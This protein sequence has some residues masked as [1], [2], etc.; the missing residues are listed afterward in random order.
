[1]NNRTNLFIQLLDALL[2]LR[3]IFSATDWINAVPDDDVL[4]NLIIV[5]YYQETYQQKPPTQRLTA[6]RYIVLNLRQQF[7]MARMRTKSISIASALMASY[8]A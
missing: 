3:R 1:M 5:A 6:Y 4:T 7:V 2:T 8:K